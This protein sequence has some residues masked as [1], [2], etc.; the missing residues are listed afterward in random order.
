MQQ[1]VFIDGTARAKPRIETTVSY[2]EGVAL[3]PFCLFSGESHKFVV[4]V[5]KGFHQKLGECPRCHNKSQWTTLKRRWMVK[6]FADWCF[7]YSMSGFWN[8][9]KY[10]DF[11]EDLRIRGVLNAFWTRYRELKGDGSERNETY[12]EH[13]EREQRKRAIQNGR[14]EA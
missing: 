8:K 10:K 7:A 3:C 2:M 1:T 11:N 14:I 12:G 13:V 6:A 5:K 9:V 4:S